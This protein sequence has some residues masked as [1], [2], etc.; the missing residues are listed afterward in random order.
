MDQNF[1]QSASQS[2]E[3]THILS[4]QHLQALKALQAPAM[5]LSGSFA[6]VLAE[7]PLI[8]TADDD[9]DYEDEA[10]LK[11]DDVPVQDDA[12]VESLDE[13][14]LDYDEE[15]A[16]ILEGDDDWASVRQEDGG[17]APDSEAEKRR[18]YMFNSVAQEVSLQEILMEQLGTEECAPKANDTR[19]HV[20]VSRKSTYRA[21]EQQGENELQS[22]AVPVVH[23]PSVLSAIYLQE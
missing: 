6:D 4:P 12:P 20:D 23:T 19:R 7:N 21:E 18:E 15:L 2:L 22:C 17:D 5:E 9:S 10:D 13:N 3:Q 16:R 14:R 1:A 11:T 8:T